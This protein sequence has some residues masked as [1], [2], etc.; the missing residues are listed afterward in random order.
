[1]SSD[2]A[3]KPLGI[4]L[5][6]VAIGFAGLAGLL[7]AQVQELPEKP[8]ETKEAPPPPPPEAKTEIPRT[9]AVLLRENTRLIDRTGQILC[10]RDDLDT[11]N[12]A[13]SVFQPKGDLG[14]FILLENKY[15]E[16]IETHTRH[17]ERDV[18]VSGTVTEYRGQNFLLLTRVFVRR[19]N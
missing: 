1:M 12:V 10:L 3:F 17:G 14:Y 18:K 19:K 16:K 13:R 7:R 8:P 9:D 11:G 6:V 2:R 5:V 15:L 4:M